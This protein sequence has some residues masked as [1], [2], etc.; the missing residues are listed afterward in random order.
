MNSKKDEEDDGRRYD[1]PTSAFY[2]GLKNH[3]KVR[4]RSFEKTHITQA[5]IE[6]A[7]RAKRKPK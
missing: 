4:H 2:R 1:T 5:K 6:R 3:Q 7:A